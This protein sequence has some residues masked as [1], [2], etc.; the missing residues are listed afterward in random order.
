MSSHETGNELHLSGALHNIS[1]CK[2]FKI[3]PFISLGV[4]PTGMQ[5]QDCKTLVYKQHS[6]F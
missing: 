2:Q 4:Q 6:P 3:H 1:L 5:N